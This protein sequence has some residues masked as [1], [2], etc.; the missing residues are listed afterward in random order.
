[1]FKN[2]NIPQNFLPHG[3][4]P[5][6]QHNNNPVNMFNQ[7]AMLQSNYSYNSYLD[8]VSMHQQFNHMMQPNNN[9]QNLQQQQQQQQQ[10]NPNFNSFPQNNFMNNNNQMMRPNMNMNMN[11]NNMN[12]GQNNQNAL[13]QP[14]MNQNISLMNPNQNPYQMMNQV[15]LGMDQPASKQFH[16]QSIP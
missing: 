4:V 5:Q 11:M 12:P 2:N 15:R 6:M 10:F 1:M 16:E 8:Q 7:N 14:I 3:Q 13:R 9:N